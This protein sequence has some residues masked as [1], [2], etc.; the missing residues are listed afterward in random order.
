[1]GVYLCCSI[2]WFGG[3]RVRCAFLFCGIDELCD[4]VD[5]I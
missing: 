4:K 2:R 5:F 1:M 3:V